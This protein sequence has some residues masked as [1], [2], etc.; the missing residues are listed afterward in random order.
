MEIYGIIQIYGI[1]A[2]LCCS[3]VCWHFKIQILYGMHLILFQ[4]SIDIVS[5]DITYQQR[6]ILKQRFPGHLRSTNI[7]IILP[8]NPNTPTTKIKTPSTQ[9]IA[10]SLILL[11]SSRDSQQ[12]KESSKFLNLPLFFISTVVS[13]LLTLVNSW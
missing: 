3:N 9:N 7:D 12:C 1:I 4:L 11:K 13:V 10:C 6:R 8:I 5:T 2:I